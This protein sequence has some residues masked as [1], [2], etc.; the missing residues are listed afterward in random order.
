M[1]VFTERRLAHD[2]LST[3]SELLLNGQRLCF[4]LEPGPGS[5]PPRKAAGKYPL[6]LRRAGGIYQDYRKRFPSALFDGIPQIVVPGR[7]YIE[8]HIGNTLN[9]TEGCSLLGASCESPR[10]SAGQHYEVRRSE[11][12]FRRVYPMLRDACKLGDCWWETLDE[13]GAP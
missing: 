10:Q 6:V 2:G 1:T 5:S 8:V 3:V 11:E 13:V 9:D 12:A 7:D 4:T